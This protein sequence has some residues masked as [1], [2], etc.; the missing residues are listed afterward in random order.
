MALNFLPLNS[1]PSVPM[2]LSQ[3]VNR[4][5]S[6]SSSE[7]AG[8]ATSHA[9]TVNIRTQGVGLKLA[10][11]INLRLSQHTEH[12]L[13]SSVDH[14]TAAVQ[15]CPEVVGCAALTGEIDY[16]WRVLVRN[17]AHYSRTIMDSLLRHRGVQDCKSSF[18]LRCWKG[19]TAVVV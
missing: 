7:V 8:C 5:L 12:S 6:A 2:E 4:M 1:K 18:V 15:A 14:F 16:L 3:G 17:M 9:C 19:A 13:R 11:F 10:A